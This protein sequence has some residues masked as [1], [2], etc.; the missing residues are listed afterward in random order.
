MYRV[1][2]T[3]RD[4]AFSGYMKCTVT[5]GIYG[6]DYREYS[7]FAQG[8]QVSTLRSGF[9]RVCRT[10]T[11]FTIHGPSQSTE[12]RLPSRSHVIHGAPSVDARNLSI[13]EAIAQPLVVS[14]VQGG[15]RE[16][17]TF[18]MIV[19]VST[20]GLWN[21]VGVYCTFFIETLSFITRSERTS[22]WRASDR[23]C[24]C[25]SSVWSSASGRK[26]STARSS[27]LPLV[28]TPK[29]YKKKKQR[30]STANTGEK[31][32]SKSK[33]KPKSKPRSRVWL[34]SS[35]R[36]KEGR[37]Q[38]VGQWSNVR[39]PSQSAIDHQ[40]SKKVFDRHSR[41]SV[42]WAPSFRD[43]VNGAQR[44][45]RCSPEASA[46]GIRHQHIRRHFSV[47]LDHAKKANKTQATKILNIMK[48]WLRIQIWIT[49]TLKEKEWV[50]KKKETKWNKLK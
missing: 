38:L 17:H 35:W 3:L 23:P 7:V 29:M 31:T 16:W 13:H 20:A 19:C 2:C 41:S 42:G 12:R 18:I 1:G 32:K 5:R 30:N 6:A 4:P 26:I 28:S 46:R 10:L 37:V 9:P 36:P 15:T 22:C 8:V 11:T 33:S 27:R 44:T 43:K 49:W 47:T 40:Y 24:T 48:S 21:F 14:A 39:P 50:K 45:H 34:H 25:G